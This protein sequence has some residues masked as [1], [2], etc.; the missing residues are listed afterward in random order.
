MSATVQRRTLRRPRHPITLRDASKRLDVTNMT[1][2][3]WRRG[4]ATMPPLLAYHVP[5]GRGH[6]VLLDEAE[7]VAWMKR[8]R[9]EHAEKWLKF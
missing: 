9:P 6:T 2:H 5:G 4:S 7:F 3:N 8:H 1:L